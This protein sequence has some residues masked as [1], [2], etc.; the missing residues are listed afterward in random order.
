MGVIVGLTIA[1]QVALANPSGADTASASQ[2]VQKYCGPVCELQAQDSAF[3]LLIEAYRQ[4]QSRQIELD[5]ESR[6]K[7][8]AHLNEE[9]D[10][11]VIGTTLTSARTM[12]AWVEALAEKERDLRLEQ[13]QTRVANFTTV[14]HCA[15]KADE[16]SAGQ[17]VTSKVDVKAAAQQLKTLRLLSLGSPSRANFQIVTSTPAADIFMDAEPADVWPEQL[18]G[19]CEDTPASATSPEQTH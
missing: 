3:S 9:P 13:L 10:S 7:A 6:L 16:A 15:R 11:L 14:Y 17:P 8:A 5:Y 2:R 4:F 12:R 1:A 19:P 18:V